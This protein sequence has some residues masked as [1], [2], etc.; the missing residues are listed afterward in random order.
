MILMFD[1][2]EGRRIGIGQRR[3]NHDDEG[4]RARRIHVAGR[5]PA[6]HRQPLRR[7]LRDHMAHPAALPPPVQRGKLLGAAAA[8]SRHARGMDHAG[9]RA[10]L[11]RTHPIEEFPT[12]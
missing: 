9:L 5:E 1:R 8:A 7:L 4:A 3:T 10:D 12:S 6:A 2:G 11:I